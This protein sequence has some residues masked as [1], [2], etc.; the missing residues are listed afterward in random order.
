MNNVET[1]KQV[2]EI[3]ELLMLFCI[4]EK[5]STQSGKPGLKKKEME[6]WSKF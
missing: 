2:V 1:T 3:Y 4:R 6:T 5:E